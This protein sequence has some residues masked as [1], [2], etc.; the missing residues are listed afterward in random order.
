MS[1]ARLRSLALVL[2]VPCAAL[3]LGACASKPRINNPVPESPSIKPDP[4]EAAKY[5]VEL[6]IAYMQ[7]GELAVAQEKL[8]RALKEAPRD[9][10]VHSALALLDERLGDPGAADE[11]FHKALHLAPR[12]PDISNN[13]AVYLCRTHRTDEGVKR[14]LATAHDPLYATPEAAYTNAAVC[15]RNEHRDAEAATELQRAINLRPNFAEAVFQMADLDIDHGRYA[16]AR[17]RIDTYIETYVAT[18]DL[19][20][21]GVRVA[22]AMHD[23]VAEQRYQQRLRVDFPDSQQTRAYA[24][25]NP[26]SG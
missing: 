19:L 25:A 17:A 5:N 26:N 16:A 6:G 24:P 11:E 8:E 13:Y 7:R 12:D 18:P 20:A 21:L 14:L 10:T 3:A 2:A 15:L 9:A 1:A 22:R 23:P 4:A